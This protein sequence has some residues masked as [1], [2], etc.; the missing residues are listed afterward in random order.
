VVG[1]YKLILEVKIFC[2]VISVMEEQRVVY[3][4]DLLLMGQG[5]RFWENTITSDE[6][7]CFAY[8]P[9]TKRQS[10]EWL[11]QNSPKSKKLRFQKSPVKTMLL[12][13]LLLGIVL[14]KEECILNNKNK[15]CPYKKLSVF[16]NTCLKTFGSHLV[17]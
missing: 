3:R 10:A 4:Q 15:L 6:T 1:E 16:Y 17:I 12:L 11:G 8:D 7:W 9:A 14:I 13:L 2:L 5:E